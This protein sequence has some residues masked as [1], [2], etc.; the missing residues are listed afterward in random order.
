VRLAEEAKRAAEERARQEEEARLREAKV[1]GDELTEEEWEASINLAEQLYVD[2]IDPDERG[3][4]EAA[5][6][7]ARDLASLSEGE[8]ETE[9]FPEELAAQARAAREAVEKFETARLENMIEDMDDDLDLDDISFEDSNFDYMG[10]SD[11]ELTAIS[12]D[13]PGLLDERAPNDAPADTDWSVLTVANLKTELTRRGLSATGK[14]ADLIARLEED[15]LKRMSGPDKSEVDVNAGDIG[16]GQQTETALDYESMTVSQLKEELK[17]RGL[18]VG[19]KKSDL[20]ERLF[21]SL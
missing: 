8:D 15:D 16:Q 9:F 20:I 5:S 18:K 10:Q 1:D 17:N 14:K 7:R 3:I 2:D 21:S 11:S 6:R 12:F 19:G 4:W 13:E